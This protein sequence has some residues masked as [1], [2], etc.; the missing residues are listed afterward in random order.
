M[1]GPPLRETGARHATNLDLPMVFWTLA[2][3]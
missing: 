3:I 2:A 1:L